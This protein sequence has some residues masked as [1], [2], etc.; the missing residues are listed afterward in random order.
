[1]TS[2]AVRLGDLVYQIREAATELRI[3]NLFDAF[4][5]FI[6]RRRIKMLS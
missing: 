1:M 3:K 4:E 6:M 2:W 5:A